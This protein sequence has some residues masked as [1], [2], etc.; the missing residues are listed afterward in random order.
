M[1]APIN[2]TFGNMSEQ[3]CAKLNNVVFLLLLHN[4]QKHI[5]LFVYLPLILEWNQSQSDQNANVWLYWKYERAGLC[6][7]K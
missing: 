4:L 3:D 5:I 7:I 2:G 1:I 6:R